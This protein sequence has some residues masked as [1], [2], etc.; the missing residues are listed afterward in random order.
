[1]VSMLAIVVFA[2]LIA[3][4]AARR[5][6]LIA[7]IVLAM[8]LLVRSSSATVYLAGAASAVVLGATP[9]CAG[10]GPR[11]HERSGMSCSR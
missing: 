8:F 11:V 9:S 5:G 2:I 7:W 6:W 4:K 10:H 3:A 1:M